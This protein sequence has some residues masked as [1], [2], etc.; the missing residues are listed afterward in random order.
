MGST[1]LASQNVMASNE[2]IVSTCQEFGGTT[3]SPTNPAC[4]IALCF[5][6][7]NGVVNRVTCLPA[8]ASRGIEGTS[9][10]NCYVITGAGGSFPSQAAQDCSTITEQYVATASERDNQGGAVD[11]C[12]GSDCP[13]PT[14]T[15]STEL[16]CIGSDLDAS[17]CRIIYYLNMAFN[18][19]ASVIVLAVIGNIV[20]AGI[21]YSTSQGDPSSAGAAKKRIRDAVMAFAMF[22]LLYSFIQWLI[23]GG[24]F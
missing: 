17:N 21:K 3:P 8:N 10:G 19:V 4:S 5:S 12:N 13:A 24:V 9:P 23:P 7:T 6:T 15:T 1:L 14:N 11:T 18:I 22:M 16:D 20:Y 2:T